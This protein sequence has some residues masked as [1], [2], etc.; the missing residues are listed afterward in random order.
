[1]V[2]ST[3][4]RP[5]CALF[6][7]LFFLIAFLIKKFRS[8]CKSSYLRSI[9]KYILTSC[10]F[11]KDFLKESSFTNQADNVWHICLHLTAV[12]QLAYYSFHLFHIFIENWKI[13]W[14]AKEI[15]KNFLLVHAVFNSVEST[16]SFQQDAK[17]GICQTQRHANL[18]TQFW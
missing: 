8:P 9:S 1:M 6:R 7:C 11:F 18:S 2:I 13:P 16:H 5:Y 15:Q 14:R 17:V 12:I 3:W 4:I 10:S